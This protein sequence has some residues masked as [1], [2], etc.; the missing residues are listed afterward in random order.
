M[1][2]R[3][4][5]RILF[6]ALGFT[7][8]G[9]TSVDYSGSTFEPTDKIKVYYDRTR[10]ERKYDVMGKATAST[11]YSYQNESLRPSLI[12]KAKACGAD[13][14][15]IESINESV[16]A[17]ARTAIDNPVDDGRLAT[18]SPGIGVDDTN[19]LPNESGA[20]TTVSVDTSR[21]VAEFLKFT[22]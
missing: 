2:G 3:I 13:A 18:D 15:L 12:E 1:S 10:I 11:W 21:I 17:P 19:L 6:A 7:F 5:S 4:V 14:I 8:G 20:Q 22:D 9:C 16:T